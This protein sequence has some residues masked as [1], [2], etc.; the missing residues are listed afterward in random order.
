MINL[1]AVIS[2][3]NIVGDSIGFSIL[4]RPFLGTRQRP[5]HIEMLRGSKRKSIILD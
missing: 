4:R 5:F 2:A 3:S 1:I